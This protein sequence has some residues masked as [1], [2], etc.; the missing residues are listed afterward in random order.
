MPRYLLAFAAFAAGCF[1]VPSSS[2]Q[3]TLLAYEGFD[4]AAGTLNGK[5]GGTGWSGAWTWTYGSG[6][7]LAVSATGMTYTGLSTTGGSATWTSGGNGI[8]EAARSLPLVDSGVVYVQM[9]TQFGATSGG[10]TP[11]L[12][13]FANGTFTGGIGGNGGTY[14]GVISIL[15]TTLT[16]APGGESSSA[17]ALSAL[18][19][20]IV[21]IDYAANTTMLWTNP[22][23]ATFDYLNPGESDAIFD[24]LAPAFDTL[25]FYTRNPAQFDEIAVF[26]VIPEP[27]TAASL[28]ASLVFV[29]V[30]VVKRRRS[31]AVAGN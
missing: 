24:G 1:A 6:G 19:L 14:G 15:D 2:G 13:F 26:S 4:Y 9:L 22:N 16:A 7:S 25:D 21:R 17:A 3:V 30:G 8:S 11:N 28:I 5:N 12:R 18:N 10:G 23:L 27:A 20:L 31:G 29:A